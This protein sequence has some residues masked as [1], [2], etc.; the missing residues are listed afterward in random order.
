MSTVTVDTAKLD[1]LVSKATAATKPLHE[2]FF[3]LFDKLEE[4]VN[5]VLPKSELVK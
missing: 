4:S 1:E 2:E 5:A 3:K